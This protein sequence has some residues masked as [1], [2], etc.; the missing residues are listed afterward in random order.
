MCIVNLY[1]NMLFILHV[2]LKGKKANM[3]LRVLAVKIKS[4][5]MYK[6]IQ[7]NIPVVYQGKFI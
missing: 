5:Y 4:T 1:Q 7:Y 6:E 2:H 3:A